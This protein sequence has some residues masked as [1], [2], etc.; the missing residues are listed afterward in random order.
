M[1]E[2]CF[3]L[4]RHTVGVNGRRAASVSRL[5]LP[6]P[7]RQGGVCGLWAGGVRPIRWASTDGA[8][9]DATA[10]PALVSLTTAV[11]RASA[12]RGP[13]GLPGAYGRGRSWLTPAH[14]G[15]T[16][17]RLSGVVTA[18]AAG[19]VGLQSRSTYGCG[20][21]GT[22]PGGP[23][24]L[25]PPSP[26]VPSAISWWTVSPPFRPGRHKWRRSGH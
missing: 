24:P 13:R 15:G 18:W 25:P 16:W 12:R 3:R 9:A 5:A 22:L 4:G 19:W 20:R 6:P 26:I 17:R 21:T 1:R 8:D 7:W 10:L 23:W 11:S 14:C 2:V